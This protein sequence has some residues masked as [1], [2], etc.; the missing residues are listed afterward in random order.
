MCSSV[1]PIDSS[2][3]YAATMIVTT[4]HSPS[5]HGP[6]GA[7]GDGT[8]YGRISSVNIRKPISTPGM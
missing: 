3:L 7:S 2:S 8:R 6:G 1:R 4:G 5:G